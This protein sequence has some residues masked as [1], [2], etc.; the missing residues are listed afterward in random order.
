VEQAGGR[1]RKSDAG[2]EFSVHGSND[3]SPLHGADAR[4]RLAGVHGGFVRV[5]TGKAG[6]DPRG[7]PA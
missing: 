7:C 4:V 1:R 3:D 2:F 5:K 6:E